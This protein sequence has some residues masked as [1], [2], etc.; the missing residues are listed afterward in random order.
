MEEKYSIYDA[1]ITSESKEKEIGYSGSLFDNPPLPS[2]IESFIKGINQIVFCVFIKSLED[3]TNEYNKP[4]KEYIISLINKYKPLL[5][6]HVLTVGYKWAVLHALTIGM[7]TSETLVRKDKPTVIAETTSIKAL[8]NEMFGAKFY[9]VLLLNPICFDKAN[10]SVTDYHKLK[11][12]WDFKS[13]KSG[14]SNNLRNRDLFTRY[15]RDK[16]NLYKFCCDILSE[17]NDQFDKEHCDAALILYNSAIRTYC[18]NP[19]IYIHKLDNGIYSDYEEDIINK[20]TIPYTS[21]WYLTD[22][23][24]FG[25]YKPQIRPEKMRYAHE[26]DTSGT[27]IQSDFGLLTRFHKWRKSILDPKSD[28]VKKFVYDCKAYIEDTAEEQKLNIAQ[29]DMFNFI[30]SHINSKSR[31]IVFSLMMKECIE[32]IQSKSLKMQQTEPLDNGF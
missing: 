18:F 12:F 23:K 25:Y 10:I 27:F 22:F 26:F 6:F 1:S 17:S 9:E 8:F 11:S 24:F 13:E 30:I 15:N 5:L 16:I 19:T 4:D 28:E 29:I 7:N 2:D 31:D 14:K 21:M 32:K 20:I 3:W